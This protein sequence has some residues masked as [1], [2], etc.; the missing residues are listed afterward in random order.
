[1]NIRQ[2]RGTG[3]WRLAVCLGLC[4]FGGLA[5]AEDPGCQVTAFP[6]GTSL[7]RTTLDTAI[8]QGGI[9]LAGT[10]VVCLSGEDLGGTPRAF[11]LGTTDSVVIQ[12]T[13]S[14]HDIRAIRIVGLDGATIVGGEQPFRFY[15]DAG[16]ESLK[17]ENIRFVQPNL[18]AISIWDGN[19]DGRIEISDLVIEG[20]RSGDLAP[21]YPSTW[22]REGIAILSGLSDVAGE[23]II[24]DNLI[25]AGPYD[26]ASRDGL[27]NVSVGVLVS[28]RGVL[29]GLNDI[30]AEITIEGN[31]ITN[32][33]GFGIQAITAN[34]IKISDNTII[35]GNFANS[36]VF[37]NLPFCAGATGLIL[38]NSTDGVI[39]NNRIIKVPALDANGVTPLCSAGIILTTGFFENAVSADNTFR[40]N[41][42]EGVGTHAVLLP[43]VAQA[44]DAVVDNVFTGSNNW[45]QFSASVATIVLGEG[46]YDNVIWAGGGTVG[47]PNVDENIIP[48]LNSRRGKK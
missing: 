18:T 45:S 47:G 28:G 27:L 41:R 15:G 12:P 4:G 46:V 44:G 11:D 5:Q 3:T 8:N 42:I 22:I 20:V 24:R 19:E 17:I 1:M 21:A 6:T 34:E 10:L 13:T 33:S 36:P 38:Q 9:G 14:A 23:I 32:W 2:R 31:T 39:S 35:P 30:T 29:G 37:P 16:L 40:R 25:D 48:G 43:N 7:D 26:P